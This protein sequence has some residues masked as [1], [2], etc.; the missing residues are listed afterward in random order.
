MA[1]PIVAARRYAEA[2]YELATRDDTLDAWADGLA[3]AS[4]LVADARVAAAVNNPARPYSERLA[5]LGRLLK[6]RAPEGV[7]KLAGLLAQRGRADRLPDVAREYTRLLDRE[8]GIVE[9]RVTSAAALSSEDTKA[10]KAWLD[11]TTG[12]QVQLV[13]SVD[14]ELI[15]GLTVRLGDTLY[16]ASVRGRLARLRTE[17]LTGARAR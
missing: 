10:V 12:K 5:T 2:A 1:R 6:G 17:L 16:D 4:A 13:A 9:A 15:G 11:R 14:P 8:R 7:I 3:L